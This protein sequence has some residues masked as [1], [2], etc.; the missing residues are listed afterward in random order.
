MV[1]APRALLPPL[2]DRRAG[3]WPAERALALAAIAKKCLEMLVR[4][5]CA[6]RDVLVELDV[7]AGRMAVVRAG[8][9]E[10]YDP[11][12]G[13]LVSTTTVPVRK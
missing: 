7:L 8:R 6:V 1:E 10:E 5:R 12:T 13:K 4:K 2:L 9:G 3:P 11:M